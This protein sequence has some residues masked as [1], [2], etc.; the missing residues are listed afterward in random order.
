M[1]R[2]LIIIFILFAILISFPLKT[3]AA[4]MDIKV[5][6]DG[7]I[8][9]FNPKPIIK[10]GTTLV[11]MR[12]FFEALGC[13]VEWD[14]LNNT[15]IGTKQGKEIRLPIGKAVG[16]INNEPVGL[17]LESQ[18]IDG[19]T[20][21]P[22]RF[23][24]EALGYLVTWENGIIRIDTSVDEE[25]YI[26][27]PDENLEKAIRRHLG[28]TDGPISKESAGKIGFLGYWPV[29]DVRDLEG[30]QHFKGLVNLKITN[31][32]IERNIEKIKE[33]DRL[34]ILTFENCNLGDLA[35]IN[36]L[37][38]LMVLT[39]RNCNLKDISFL[40][41]NAIITALNLEENLI[42]DISPLATMKQLTRVSM[43][44]NPVADITPL[45][46]LHNLGFLGLF[47]LRW[48]VDDDIDE[49]LQIHR[50]MLTR[51]HKIIDKNITRKMSDRQ[52]AR[53]LHDYVINNSKYDT[54]ARE[55]IN[56]EYTFDTKAP[57]TPYGVIVNKK[58]V[59]EGYALTIHLLYN[60]AG[61]ECHIV[62]GGRAGSDEITHA[63][64][65]AKIDGKYYHVDA[66]W[67]ESIPDGK[68]RHKYFLVTD[69]VM[70]KDHE[71]DRDYYPA[72]PGN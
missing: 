25:Q 24:G 62:V 46:E 60:L 21:I 22:L 41:N 44:N 4:A 70:A 49:I 33:L 52:K 11:P 31:S 71:W 15:A 35:F 55:N 61:I 23:V 30:I 56:K 20:F 27:I 63:W 65:I 17:S 1:K 38:N 34:E 2:K 64:N 28:L 37:K 72:C 45:E 8:K 7:S 9:E 54:K 5:Y 29:S 53:V 66:T 26:T 10:N 50:E 13:T 3:M 59:C 67:D 12:S 39:I 18:L 69:K 6:I 57:Y 40:E 32:N 14:S 19:H 58:G 51:A 43:D 16:Y 47:G 42:T 48:R 36:E 68:I